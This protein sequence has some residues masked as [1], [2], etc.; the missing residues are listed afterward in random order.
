MLLKLLA[1]CHIILLSMALQ[2]SLLAAGLGPST[3][4]LQLVTLNASEPMI[5]ENWQLLT[6][7]PV[8]LE[9]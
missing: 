6:N 9:K 7:E 8:E 5:G 3:N 4:A 1:S 2:P